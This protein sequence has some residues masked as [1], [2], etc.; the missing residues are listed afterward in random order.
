[1]EPPLCRLASVWTEDGLPCERR[2]S[3]QRMDAD[4]ERIMDAVE[5]DRLADRR[6]DH[7]R[8]ADDR[9][10]VAADAIEPI[11]GPQLGVGTD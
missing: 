3:G 6:V 2:R 10:L 7:P 4:D 8:V 11:E 1:M 9:R 5:G